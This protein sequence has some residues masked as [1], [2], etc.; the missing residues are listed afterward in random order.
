MRRFDLGRTILKPVRMISETGAIDKSYELLA[1]AKVRP[2]IDDARSEPIPR[3]AVRRLPLRTEDPELH[4][5]VMALPSALEGPDI[6]TDPGIG[7]TLFVSD[8]L[9]KALIEAGHYKG[10]GG[11]MLLRTVR[12]DGPAVPTASGGMG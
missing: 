3:R 12:I 8:R 4:S 6:W 7:G 1:T 5:G 10:R 9:A 2:T 11:G